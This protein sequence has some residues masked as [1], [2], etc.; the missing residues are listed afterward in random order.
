MGFEQL[1][2]EEFAVVDGHATV[3]VDEGETAAGPRFPVGPGV[4]QRIQRVRIDDVR[5]WPEGAGF[6]AL[7][8]THGLDDG[9]THRF[10]R[11]DIVF[12]VT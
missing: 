1:N 3:A 2:R 12:H 7:H 9:P 6:S 11:L 10:R 4:E 8:R 5:Q